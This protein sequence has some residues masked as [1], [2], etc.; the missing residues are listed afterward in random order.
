MPNALEH[1]TPDPEQYAAINSQRAAFRVALDA[2]DRA[3]A[4]WYRE[5]AKARLQE[6]SMWA[7]KA[8]THGEP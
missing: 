6:A 5:Q 3:P 8:V 4:G 7:S 1:V 2:I